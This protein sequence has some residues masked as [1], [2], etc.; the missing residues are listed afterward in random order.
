MIS[1]KEVKSN[2]NIITLVEAGNKYLE[3]I[4]YTDHGPRH[5]SYVSKMAGNILKELDFDERSV[6]LAKIAGWVH[7]VGNAINRNNH[8]AIGATL[9][10]EI[11]KEIGLNI[12]DTVDIVTA[13][14]NHE[15]QTGS[16]TNEISAALVIADKSDAHKSRVRYGKPDMEDIHD[17]VNFSIQKNSLIIN[18]ET[19]TIAQSIVMDSK[20]SVFEYLEIYMQR[21]SMC[22]TAA[23]FLNCKFHL[24]INDRIINNN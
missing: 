9:L 23:K 10:F 13:V 22:E 20:S 7:D 24:I 17:R 8:G 14:G 5:I 19:R 12:K 6:E 1:L 21:I 4:G 2:Q 11:L 3:M 15:E 18:K 16:V